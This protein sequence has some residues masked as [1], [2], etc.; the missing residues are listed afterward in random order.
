MMLQ[1]LLSVL[2]FALL[3]AFLGVLISYVPRLDL[4]SVLVV[5]VVLCGYDLFVHRTPDGAR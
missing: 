5:C 4:G 1:H 2:A 3:C